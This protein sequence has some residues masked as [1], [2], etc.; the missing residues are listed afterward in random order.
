[1]QGE[2]TVTKVEVQNGGAVSKG[3]DNCY[4]SCFVVAVLYTLANGVTVKGRIT[5]E[6][7]KNL[8]RAIEQEKAS[9]AA[10]SMSCNPDTGMFTTRFTIGSRGLQPYAGHP[11]SGIPAPDPIQE[12]VAA[13]SARQWA[14]SDARTP[15]H[16]GDVGGVL[17]AD[18]HVY[19]DA[20][21]GL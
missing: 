15:F 16:E 8:P 7:K 18:N 21:S 19:S 12:S 14:K 9:I 5:S 1:M 20:D 2:I 11:A 6:R 4:R 3:R 17:G 13:S 10:G